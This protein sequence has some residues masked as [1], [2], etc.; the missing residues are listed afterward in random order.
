MCRQTC[1]SMQRFLSHESQFQACEVNSVWLPYTDRMHPLDPVAM[2]PSLLLHAS[3]WQSGWAV[4]CAG[5]PGIPHNCQL[6]CVW[7]GACARSLVSVRLMSTS[8]LRFV[9]V[10]IRDAPCAG[11]PWRYSKHQLVYHYTGERDILRRLVAFAGSP[12]DAPEV[13]RT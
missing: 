13:H 6:L 4:L 12:R 10:A 5:H 2:K 11:H 3:S 8:P 7:S 1:I 9:Q